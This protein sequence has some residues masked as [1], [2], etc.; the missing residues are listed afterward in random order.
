M[1]SFRTELASLQDDLT[2]LRPELASL[3]G[4]VDSILAEPVVKSQ[5]A[6][7]VLGDDK[8]L[9]ALLSLEDR[10]DQTQTTHAQC[11]RH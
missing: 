5:A 1:Y 4:D 3:P 7:S 6:L 11:N 9:G 2:C 10:E 8:I